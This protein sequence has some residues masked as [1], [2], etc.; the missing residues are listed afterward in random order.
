MGLGFI[1]ESDLL[2]H[3]VRYSAWLPACKRRLK[4]IKAG[5][6]VEKSRRLRYFTFC[7]VG[8]IDVLML[9]VA[10]IIRQS[11]SG[12]FDTVVYFDRTPE[13]VIETSKRIPGAIGFPGDFV[14]VILA[15]DPD[16]V[17]VLDSDEMLSA[18]EDQLDNAET[19]K[20]Q[21]L[22]GQRHSFIGKFPFDVINLDL[23]EYLFK[24]N[25]PLPGRLVNALRKIFLWQ[26]R[27]FTAGNRRAP[28]YLDGFSLMFT[29]RIGPH[30]L[31]SGYLEM[32]KSYLRDNLKNNEEFIPLLENRSGGIT[33]IDSLHATN[34][35]LFFKIAVPKVLANILIETDWY[36]DPD[37]GVTI[38]EFERSPEGVPPYKMLHL[39]MDI[40]RQNPTRVNRPPGVG[41]DDRVKSAYSYVV[42]KIIGDAEINIDETNIDVTELQNNLDSIIS[43]RKKYCP[44]D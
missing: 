43:R 32:L 17:T 8:A 22:L 20:K 36:I 23:E 9:D 19:R 44:D 38:I 14:N 29:T 11:N 39:V 1:Y 10:K 6:P 16:E 28:Q 15:D 13:L 37:F 3:Y 4:I 33:D 26:Q 34:F 5:V 31:G 12:R 27:S 42:S 41:I 7:A 18:L 25:D 40:K 30:E 2:K 24:P 35:E 21:I